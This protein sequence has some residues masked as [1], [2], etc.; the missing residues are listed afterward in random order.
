MTLGCLVINIQLHHPNMFTP[1]LLQ[2]TGHERQISPSRRVDHRSLP[3]G[4]REQHSEL[5]WKECFTQ[6]IHSMSSW[7]SFLV[8]VGDGFLFR[9]DGSG[10][11]LCV[12]RCIMM[13]HLSSRLDSFAFW[14]FRPFVRYCK[15]CCPS[16]FSRWWK[17]VKSLHHSNKTC[18]CKMDVPFSISLSRPPETCLVYPPKT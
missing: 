14:H 10:L 4:Y 2:V 15:V 12:D 11:E 6:G 9:S 16:C 3:A 13:Y 18:Q 5:Y 8:A 17:Q 7:F 1:G